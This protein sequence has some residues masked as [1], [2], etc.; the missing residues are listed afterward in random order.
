[1]A[2]LLSAGQALWGKAVKHD[3]I[4]SGSVTHILQNLLANPKVWLGGLLY[5]LATLL[6]FLILSKNKF[7]AVQIT[8]TA[9][10]IVLSTLIAIVFF[11][12]RPNPVNII[13]ISFVAIGLVCVLQK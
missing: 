9:L 4:M 3:N 1:M 7:F 6:Y 13:G 5:I 12:E 2:L 10:S 11:H 8:M